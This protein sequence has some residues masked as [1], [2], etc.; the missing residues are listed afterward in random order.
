MKRI[1]LVLR[2]S[3]ERLE[4]VGEIVWCFF[5][6]M[7]SRVDSAAADIDRPFL[8]DREWVAVKLFEVV[9]Q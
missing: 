3:E 6:H 8:P 2:I 7:V 4:S 9:F 1:G 5:G